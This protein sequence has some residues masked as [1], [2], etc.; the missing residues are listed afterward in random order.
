MSLLFYVGKRRS[1]FTSWSKD[2]YLIFNAIGNIQRKGMQ[3][4]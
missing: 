1:G 3:F 2:D 4:A